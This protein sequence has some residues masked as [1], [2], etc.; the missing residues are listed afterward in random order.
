MSS[1]WAII[2]D[3]MSAAAVAG[4]ALRS[5]T[6]TKALV[7]GSSGLAGRVAGF[8]VESVTWYDADK[9]LPEAMAGTIAKRAEQEKPVA[10][11]ASD[12]ATSRALLGP[13][14]VVLGAAVTGKVIAVK[15]DGDAAT[16]ER[17]VADSEAVD[18]LAAPGSV[19]CTIADGVDEAEASEPVVVSEGAFDE[20][21]RM[22]VLST[23]A[24]GE[25]GAGLQQ[26]E[27]VVGV[28]LGI[29]SKESLQLINDLA[30]ALGAEVACTLPLC[31]NYHWFEHNRVV[32][33]S[34]QKISPRLYMAFGSSGAPQHMTGVRN[35]KLIVAVNND[36]EAPIFRA[37]AYGIVG[38]AAKIL[39]VLTQAVKQL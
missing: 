21:A 10:I 15:V 7:F 17:L 25:G 8:G 19:V 27:R 14:A 23:N 6:P 35:S 1:V 30:E 18:V 29:G 24:E 32:G 33:T 2:T 13:V 31:D 34:T 5:G 20:D 26:A 9:T 4:V 38:D 36:A 37:C 11:V 39:P 3:E 16:V 12:S 22:K 28:G